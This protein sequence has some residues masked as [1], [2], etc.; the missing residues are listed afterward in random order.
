MQ[1]DPPSGYTIEVDDLT[2]EPILTQPTP[3]G[4]HAL[5]KMYSKNRKS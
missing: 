4:V 3:T 1:L 5:C 2:I